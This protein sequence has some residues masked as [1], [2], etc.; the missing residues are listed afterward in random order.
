MPHINEKLDIVVDVYIVFEDKVLLRKHDK[1]STYLSVGGHIDIDEDPNTA[2]IREAKEETGIDIELYNSTGIDDFSNSKY[3]SLIPPM[4]MNIHAINEI[5]NH[6][7]LIYFAKTYNN[8]VRP[9]YTDDV[10]NDWVWVTETE[11][12]KLDNCDEKIKFYASEALKYLV[13]NK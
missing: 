2:A 11:L 1:Y 8:Q 6:C 10:S 5:H 4:Y 9:E 13:K 3:R 7:S 12:K